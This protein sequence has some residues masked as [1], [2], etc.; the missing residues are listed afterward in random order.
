M[1][2]LILGHRGMLGQMAMRYFGARAADVVTITQR[3]TLAPDCPALAQVA[4]SDADVVLNCIGCLSAGADPG[5]MY[6]TNALL[7]LAVYE[8]LP[9]AA[10][11]I[12]QS[13]DGVFSGRSDHAGYAVD[14]ACDAQDDYGWSKRLG[15][16]GLVGKERAAVLRC[17]IIGP[18][19]S[20]EGTGLVAWLRRQPRDPAVSGYT[21]HRWNGI[22]TLEWCRLVERL[23]VSVPMDRRPSGVLQPGAASAVTKAELLSLIAAAFGTGHVIRPTVAAQTIDRVLVPTVVSPPLA[24]QIADLAKYEAN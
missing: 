13:T 12:H 4:A 23:F 14:A 24:G 15:E 7:P 16:L 11:L 10:F 8:R 21:N 6:R 19:R 1:R 18:D 9:P 5:A 2:I 17:S 20:P 3:F 22:T